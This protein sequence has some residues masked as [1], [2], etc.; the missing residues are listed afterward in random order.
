MIFLCPDR[1]EL[2]FALVRSRAE[3]VVDELAVA[4]QRLLSCRGGQGRL[5]A[6]AAV[7]GTGQ[8]GVVAGDVTV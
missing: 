5:Q 2:S 3:D 7:S 1:L 4:L 6:D 8:Q